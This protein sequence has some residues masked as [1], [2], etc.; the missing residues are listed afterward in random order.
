MFKHRYSFGETFV[1]AVAA[2]LI[3]LGLS[4]VFVNKAHAAPEPM[5]T[6]QATFKTVYAQC[7]RKEGSKTYTTTA[8][9]YFSI[10][11]GY[12]TAYQTHVVTN[13]PGGSYADFKYN[14]ITRRN[15]VPAGSAAQI[16]K[17]M[18][19]DGSTT[20]YRIVIGF[21]NPGFDTQ[22]TKNGSI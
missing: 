12:R 20:S 7:T 13:Y 5:P 19:W 14:G 8:Y 16:V 22:C 9:M 10:S 11:N 2:I 1:V 3:F 21:S 6:T 15:S 17:Y 4:A 18:A